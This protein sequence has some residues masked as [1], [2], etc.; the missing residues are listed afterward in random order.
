[1]RTL[2]VKLILAFLVVSLTVAVLAAVVVR[3]LTVQEFNRLVLDQAQNRFVSDMQV[4]YQI[5]GSWQGVREYLHRRALPQAQQPLQPGQNLPVQ[6]LPPQPQ[7]AVQTPALVFALLDPQGLVLAPAGPFRLNDRVPPTDL[8]NAAPVFVDGQVVG[9]AVA[10]GELPPLD[11]R[12]TR[13]LARTDRALLYTGIGATAIALLLGIWLARTLTRPLGELT[14]AIRAMGR[15]QLEQQVAVRSSDELGELAGAF[16]QMSADLAKSNQLRRQ[17]TADIAHD[18]RTPL[19]VISGYVEAMRDQV[20]P[21]TTERYEMIFSEVQHLQHLVEDLRT[22]SLADAGELRLARQPLPPQA[23]LE[24]CAATHARLAE[25]KGIRLTVQAQPDLPPVNV[26]AE[27]MAQV[28]GNLVTNALRH[29]PAGGQISL[30]AEAAANAADAATGG[31]RL[32]VQDTGEGIPPEALPRIFDRFYR[33]DDSR[34]RSGSESG[35]GLA[36]VRSL[37][38]AHGGSISVQSAPGQ[39]TTFSLLLN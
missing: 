14:A 28:L 21:P 15:G 7:P 10:T 2:T 18:L 35:L 20:L 29:T 11:P 34:Q 12:E 38:E 39:G 23:L 16:N 13:Y 36:I 5:N 19:T 22:L 27:R 1:M 25:Q 6:P 24:R 4:Y 37:V 33:V 32:R 26:D 17:M 30:S 3:W 8:V 31:V 9:Y